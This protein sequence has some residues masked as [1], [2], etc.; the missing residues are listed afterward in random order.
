M[1]K[2][3]QYKNKNMNFMYIDSFTKMNVNRVP[4]WQT[5]G[6]KLGTLDSMALNFVVDL[7]NRYMPSVFKTLREF[8]F[9][10]QPILYSIRL[11]LPI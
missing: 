11:F 4:P 9:I 3:S 6:G 5:I 2:C 8:I 7:I 10:F 1:S